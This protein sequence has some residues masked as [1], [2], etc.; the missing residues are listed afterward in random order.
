MAKGRFLGRRKVFAQCSELVKAHDFAVHPL[1]DLPDRRDDLVAV[2]A[3]KWF[4]EHNI[5]VPADIKV[6]G[7]DNLPQSEYSIPPLTSLEQPCATIGRKS[8]ELLK[9]RGQ[10]KNGDRITGLRKT[11]PVA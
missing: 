11:K 5:N 7:F 4:M 10:W 9:N 3:I 8:V 6:M 2:G 1:G